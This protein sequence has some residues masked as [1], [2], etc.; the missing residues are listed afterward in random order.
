[1]SAATINAQAGQFSGV[2]FFQTLGRA[3]DARD[4]YEELSVLND[5]ELAKRGIDR[6]DVVQHVLAKLG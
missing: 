4:T 3:L 2:R 1:M 6:G 5:A